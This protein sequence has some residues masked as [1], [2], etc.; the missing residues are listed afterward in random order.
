MSALQCA[1]W[2]QAY[3]WACTSPAASGAR[4]TRELRTV[5]AQRGHIG[6]GMQV[7]LCGGQLALRG[8]AA[9]GQQR[10]RRRRRVAVPPRQLALQE[11]AARR[12]V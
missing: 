10:E 12:W 2:Q 6:D 5:A 1:L 8:A 9:L 3:A 7:R 4:G 11:T